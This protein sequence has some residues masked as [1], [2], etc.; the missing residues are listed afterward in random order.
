M[1]SIKP[2]N[3]EEKVVQ[4][5]PPSNITHVQLETP[6]PTNEIPEEEDDFCMP[7]GKLSMFGMFTAATT[8]ID[9]QDF[10]AW[11]Q[12]NE[13]VDDMEDMLKIQNST[14]RK[15]A[16]ESKKEEELLFRVKWKQEDEVCYFDQEEVASKVKARHLPLQE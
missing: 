13:E 3:W 7:V 14:T 15:I 9:E 11:N 6:H 12:Q 4:K 16:C 5:N 10:N 8:K 1:E 2:P